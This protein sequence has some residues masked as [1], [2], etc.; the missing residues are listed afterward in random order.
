M[1]FLSLVYRLYICSWNSIRK[2]NIKWQPRKIFQSF[3]LWIPIEGLKDRSTW[4]DIRKMQRDEIEKG[5]C[6]CFFICVTILIVILDQL[7]F[8]CKCSAS[9]VHTQPEQNYFTSKYSLF[10]NTAINQNLNNF[11][12]EDF[13][14]IFHSGC[15]LWP[16]PQDKH[17]KGVFSAET[18]TQRCLSN[19]S[20]KPRWWE[21]SSSCIL[22]SE[23]LK[24]L[25][26]FHKMMKHFQSQCE[27]YNTFP[28]TGQ[29]IKLN[30]ITRGRLG[31]LLQREGVVQ[32]EIFKW[33][34]GDPN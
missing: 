8:L 25:S 18:Q 5:A 32:P 19:T 27:D 24:M 3:P 2:E 26:T 34:G 30:L 28:F 33:R 7:L 12:K 17:N 22:K 6:P 21:T 4:V 15:P 31:L 13:T 11:R 14:I 16:G 20:L 23:G 10:A 1:S 9:R 29:K